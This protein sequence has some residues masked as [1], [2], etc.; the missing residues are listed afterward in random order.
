MKTRPRLGDLPLEAAATAAAGNWR[1]FDAFVWD[2]ADRLPDP[3]RWCVHYTH[4]RDSGL[5]DHSNAEQ[6]WAALLPHL[7]GD[8]PDAAVERHIHW[9]VGHIDG[10]CVRVDR[11]GRITDAFRTLHGLLASLSEYPVLDEEHYGELQD[12]ATFQNV[13]AAVDAACETPDAA[14]DRA[15]RVHGWLCEHRPDALENVD[16]SGG[17]PGDGDLRAAF[18]ALNLAAAA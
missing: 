9:A 12:E 5:L 16:D 13:A 6:I 11:G 14:G 1:R 7:F 18:A 8:D 10:V 3:E 17:W 15:E 4:H 2:G